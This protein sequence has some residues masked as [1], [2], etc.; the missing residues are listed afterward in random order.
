MAKENK[1]GYLTH[2]VRIGDSI[3]RLAIQYG[4]S[5]WREIVFLN[6]LEYPYIDSAFVKSEEYQGNTKVAKVGDSILVPAAYESPAIVSSDISALEKFTYGSDL[7]IYAYDETNKLAVRLEEKGELSA[8]KTGDLAIAAGV[9]NLRQRLI[10]RLGVPKGSFI[11][12][13]E[14]GS[15]LH[16]LI[17]LKDTQQN[18]TKIQLEVQRCILSDPLVKGLNALTTYKVGSGR[19]GVDAGVVPVPPYKPFR[20]TENIPI[21]E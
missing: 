15:E 14:F 20:F 12:H 11:L 8:D 9:A 7:D 21:I 6:G 1:Y 19:L 2:I 10:I 18:R 16:K 17:G 13:P 3:Q 5:D 4:I